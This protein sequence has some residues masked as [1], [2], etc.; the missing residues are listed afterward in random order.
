MSTIGSILPTSVVQG[1]SSTSST[2]TGG[3]QGLT[4]SDFINMM[5][6]QL[7]NQDP[8]N[9]TS[10]SDLLAQMS[11]IGQ[12]QSSDQLQTTLTGL[13]L[14][15]Q[16]GAAAGLIGKQVQGTDANSNAVTGTV[17]G[18]TITQNPASASNG[19]VATSNV[20]LNLDSGD[21]IPL[22]NVTAIA[23]P[24]TTGTG[25]SSGASGSAATSGTGA[26]AA[27]AA[28]VPSIPQA[29]AAA[30]QNVASSVAN[31]ASGLASALTGL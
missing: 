14:Q 17:T 11:Q 10:S 9:P 1:T 18:V 25:T 30:V 16:I 4:P 13:T 6:T 27:P 12:L 24:A 23:P 8:L 31:T 28:A 29:A 3:L 26:T 20:N 5:V 19:G 15:N 7:Q 22:S 21:S 2:S